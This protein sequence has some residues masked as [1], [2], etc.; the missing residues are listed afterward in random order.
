MTSTF[1]RLALALVALSGAAFSA[2]A[3]SA[4]GRVDIPVSQTVLPNGDPRYSVPV[5]VGNGPAIAAQLDTG[6]F[7]LRVLASALD[8]GSY[9]ATDLHRNYGFGSGATFDGVLARGTV[10]VGGVTTEAPV[11]FQLVQKVVC[12]DDKPD[13]PASRVKPDDYRIGGD[14]YAGQGFPAILGLSMLRAASDDSAQNPLTATGPRSWILILPR[15]GSAEPGHLI[16]DPDDSDRAGFTLLKL[17]P[18]GGGRL[19]GW[20]DRALPGCVIEDGASRF[21]GR[22]LIDSGAPGLSVATDTVKSP[23]P[24]GKGRRGRIE[25]GGT[26]GPVSVPFTSGADYA[27]RVVLH[28][29]RGPEGAAQLAVGTLPYLSY[30]VLYDSQAGT[31]GFKARGPAGP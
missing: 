25:I 16:V 1:T 7:G 27:S 6:S 29:Q 23:K 21:C 20:A 2:D 30:A 19:A 4:A 10:S 13:C 14:G 18:A 22:T 24:W 9:E 15:P 26:G 31:I 12:A 28:P 17:D 11:L 5:S 3:A 8:P